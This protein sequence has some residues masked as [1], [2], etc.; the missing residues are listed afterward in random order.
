MALSVG[1]W[2]LWRRKG[3]TEHRWIGR[4]WVACMVVGNLSALAL[5]GKHGFTLFTIL[6]AYSLVSVLAAFVMVWRKPTP[7]WR[8]WHYY[9]MSYGYLGVLAAGLARVPI[10]L[11]SEF[12]FGVFGTMAVVFGLGGWWTEQIARQRVIPRR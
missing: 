4:A 2:L 8:V 9:L 5:V 6:A 10:L 7:A 11:G 12:W 3:T 1:P